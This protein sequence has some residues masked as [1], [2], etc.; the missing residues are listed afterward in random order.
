M[1][2]IRRKLLTPRQR[3]SLRYKQTAPV[4]RITETRQ[5]RS[6]RDGAD[7]AAVIQAVRREVFASRSAC[8]LCG[9]RRK[10]ECKGLPDQMHE[11]PSRA[12]TRGK[13]PRERFNLR[14]CGR[15]CVACHCDVTA[16]RV[17]VVF[18]S[19]QLRWLGPVS[20]VPV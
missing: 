7:E 2:R 14:V 18:E 13:P 20:L 9:G 11:D 8:Q 10:D 12:L 1:G 5:Q 16:H 19:E 6:D 3:S 4:G 15:A 17:R